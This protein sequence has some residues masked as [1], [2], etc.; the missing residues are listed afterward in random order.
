MTETTQATPEKESFKHEERLQFSDGRIGLGFRT[1]GDLIE[2]GEHKYASPDTGVGTVLIK[3]ESGRRFAVGNHTVVML[4]EFNRESGKYESKQKGDISG[5]T[6]ESVAPDGLPSITIGEAW[7]VIGQED[8]VTSVLLDYKDTTP[9]QADMEQAGF[10]NPF[11]SA[12]DIL[13]KYSEVL[14]GSA[15]NIVTSQG[16]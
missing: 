4:P 10:P 1:P 2:W 16:A 6:F 14:H 9:G 11:D 7:S 13:D 3:T 5:A 12:R 8:P 15:V